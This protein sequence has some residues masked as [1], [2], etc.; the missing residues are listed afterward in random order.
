LKGKCLGVV[1]PKKEDSESMD[2]IFI[3]QVV[4]GFSNLVNTFLCFKSHCIFSHVIR[5]RDQNVDILFQCK[6]ELRL[7]LDVCWN[8]VLFHSVLP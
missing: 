5:T 8:E 6:V 7:C 1:F 2:G 3:V 4:N